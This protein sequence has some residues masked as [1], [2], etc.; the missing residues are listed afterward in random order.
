MNHEKSNNPFLRGSS[1]GYAP[2]ADY[3]SS[4]GDSMQQQTYSPPIGPPPQNSFYPERLPPAYD[5]AL[6][7]GIPADS[8]VILDK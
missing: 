1:R 3:S 8:I 6:N 5:S 7:T 2:N 4:M